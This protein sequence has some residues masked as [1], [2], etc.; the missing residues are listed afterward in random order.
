ML[1]KESLKLHS[2]EQLEIKQ[3]IEIDPEVSKSRY[4][5]ESYF[6]FPAALYINKET[7]SEA[8]FR[9]PLKSYVRLRLPKFPLADFMEGGEEYLRLKNFLNEPTGSIELRT[10][11]LKRYALLI[12]G[13]FKRRI[14]TLLESGTEEDVTALVEELRRVIAASRPLLLSAADLQEPALAVTARAADEYLATILEYHGKRLL[15]RFDGGLKAFLTENALYREKT[16]PESASWQPREDVLYRWRS[17]KKFISSQLFLTVKMREGN[18]WLLQS[19]Y[20]IAAAV[21]MIFATVVAFLWQG[22]YGALSWNLFLALVIAYIFKDR[23]KDWMRTRLAKLFRRWLPSRR[24]L[25]YANDGR[26]VGVCRESFEFVKR[27]LRT[28][29]HYVPFAQE[30]TETIFHYRK[31]VELKNEWIHSYE[32]RS[33]LYDITRL[34]VMPWTSNIDQQFEELPFADEDDERA[35]GPV[36]KLYHVYLVRR[37]RVENPKHERFEVTRLVLKHD[38]LFLLERVLAGEKS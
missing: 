14:K 5:V 10:S 30:E 15:T 11:A 19:L 2:A 1:V 34:G 36:A 21:S 22:K 8:D 6:F 3:E 26:M 33:S 27:A 4:S 16:Y 20:G 24:Q 28:K 7:Y 25:I 23:L 29:A 9:R 13:S 38:G 12:K 18:P 35:H 32:N 31:D 37:I 17:L